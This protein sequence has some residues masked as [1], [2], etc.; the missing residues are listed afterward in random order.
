[1][2]TALALPA[3]TAGGR[4]GGG[5]T[6]WRRMRVR[7]VVGLGLGHWWMG[8]GEWE[9]VTSVDRLSPPSFHTRLNYPPPPTHTH[10][11]TPT[12][13]R[14]HLQPELAGS[15]ADP[16]GDHLWRRGSRVKAVRR[17]AALVGGDRGG[18]RRRRGDEEGGEGGG[19]GYGGGRGRR[20]GGA[21]HFSSHGQTPT[22]TLTRNQLHG[23]NINNKNRRGT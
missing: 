15:G 5:V 22:R 9:S 19:C 17:G 16:R 20:G 23:T 7:V 10:F 4:R 13:H 3:P 12:S 21:L 6:R 1:M 11:Y 8:V 14:V 2:P 18:W